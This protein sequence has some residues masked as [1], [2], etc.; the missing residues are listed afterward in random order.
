MKATITDREV[1]FSELGQ[2]RERGYAYNDEEEIRGFRA[3][4]A[5]IKDP[6]G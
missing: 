5:S 4:N 2:T 6:S 3:I 1:L